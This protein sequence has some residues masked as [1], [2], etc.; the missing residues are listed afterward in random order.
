[1]KKKSLLNGNQRP[2][3][4]VDAL[5]NKPAWLKRALNPKTKMTA[6]QETVQTETVD[7]MLFPRIRMVNGELK[8]FKDQAYDEAMKRKDFIK[9]KDDKEAN[10]FARVLTR[11]IGKLR[12]LNKNGRP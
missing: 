1:M 12:K 11:K 8:N 10:A 4:A 2:P 7:G 3:D 9:F 5:K 6:R